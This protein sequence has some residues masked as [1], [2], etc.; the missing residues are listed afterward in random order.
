[1][2]FS[3]FRLAISDWRTTRKVVRE[4]IRVRGVSG[5]F[6]QIFRQVYYSIRKLSPSRRRARRV[7]E[8]A[9]NASY[10]DFDMVYGVDTTTPI[11][12]ETLA[13]DSD[14]WLFG[15]RYEPI[16]PR[17]FH[18][19]MHAAG[20]VAEGRVFI[21]LG[22]GKGRALLLASEYPFKR[23][24][25]VEFASE[26]VRLARENLLRYRNTRQVCRD[27]E[28]IEADAATYSFPDDPLVIY[29]FN[30]FGPEVLA[31]VVEAVRRALHR[32]P[33]P[34]TILYY[35]PVHDRLWAGVPELQRVTAF[36]GDSRSLSYS[37]YQSSQ[38]C[39]G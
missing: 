3:S 6:A 21:D 14:N 33:R 37:I 16:V 10:R 13:T 4:S 25:G 36:P 20:E 5:T 1:M 34:V 9:L 11:P 18:D 26:L 12:I 32:Q 39:V 24:I 17:E 8:E 27:L 38:P 15:N 2:P 35:K 22:C 29:L 23:I 19:M 7:R 31:P 30:P 28:V